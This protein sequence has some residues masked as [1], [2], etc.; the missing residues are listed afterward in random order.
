MRLLLLEVQIINILILTTSWSVAQ[1]GKASCP[2][3][4]ALVRSLERMRRLME[5]RQEKKQTVSERMD[6][7][8]ERHCQKAPVGCPGPLGPLGLLWA[9]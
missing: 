8:S 3:S 2:E 7:E 5:E 1:G 6:K 9:A 4:D